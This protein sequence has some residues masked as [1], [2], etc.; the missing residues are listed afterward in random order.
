M[1]AAPAENADFLM[2]SM[3]TTLSSAPAAMAGVDLL[4]VVLHE[5]GYVLGEDRRPA[6]GDFGGVGRPAPSRW[7]AAPSADEMA[8]ADLMLEEIGPGAGRLPTSRLVDDLFAQW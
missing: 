3:R 4:T 5:V 1:V 2:G 8:A 7:R 6:V